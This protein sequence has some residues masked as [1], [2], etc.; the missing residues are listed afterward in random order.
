MRRP[1]CSHFIHCRMSREPR[2]SLAESGPKEGSKDGCQIIES[3]ALRVRDYDRV[4]SETL[5]KLPFEALASCLLLPAGVRTTLGPP[6]HLHQPSYSSA[7]P[8]FRLRPAAQDALCRYADE[9]SRSDFSRAKRALCG[10]RKPHSQPAG[11][12]GKQT[13]RAETLVHSGTDICGII[14]RS[15]K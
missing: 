7:Y 15:G 13:T 8:E 14:S 2:E 6:A 12:Q 5:K 11:R 4:P 3:L 10:C 9:L 1:N